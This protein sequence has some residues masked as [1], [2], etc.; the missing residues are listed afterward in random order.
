MDKRKD[1]LSE[2]NYSEDFEEERK[3]NSRRAPPPPPPPADNVQKV[4]NQIPSDQRR[5]P[6]PDVIE[7]PNPESNDNRFTAEPEEEEEE[8]EDMG[9]VAQPL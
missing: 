2:E 8:E 4:L 7:L 9:E 3:T 5:E 1:T 6:V